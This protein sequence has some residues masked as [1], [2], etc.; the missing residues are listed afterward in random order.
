MNWRRLVAR[1][2]LVILACL[3]VG[4][5]VWSVY[6]L[7]WEPECHIPPTCDELGQT[8]GGGLIRCSR[9][10]IEVCTQPAIENP[11]QPALVVWLGVLG[12]RVLWGLTRFTKWSWQTLRRRTTDLGS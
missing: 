9:L 1:E 6:S 5:V 2:W 12:I 4:L 11:L 7:T 8:G 10:P 3:V